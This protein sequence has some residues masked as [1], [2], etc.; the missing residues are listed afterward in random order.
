MPLSVLY[1]RHARI[2]LATGSCHSRIARENVAVRS[3]IA[4][5]GETETAGETGEKA[6]KRERE[7]EREKER[8]M[9]SEIVASERSG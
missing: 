8:K 4:N 2:A 1:E 3:G 6:R 5:H 9:E 7:K